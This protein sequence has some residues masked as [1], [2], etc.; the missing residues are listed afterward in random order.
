MAKKKQL[1]IEIGPQTFYH[2]NDE[3]ALFEWIAKI[4]CVK[5]VEAYDLYIRSKRISR[6]DL[7]QLIGIFRRYEFDNIEQLFIFRNKYN[8]GIF[9]RYELLEKNE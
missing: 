5:K 4:T 6:D 1:T 3:H 7:R 9:D 8:E 2:I